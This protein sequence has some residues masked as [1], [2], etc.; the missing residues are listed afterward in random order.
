MENPSTTDIIIRDATEED[1]PFMNRVYNYNV[2]NSVGLFF[3]SPVTDEYR[4]RWFRT[5]KGKSIAGE[6]YPCLIGLRKGADGQE[7]KFGYVCYIPWMEGEEFQRV[8]EISLYIAQEHTGLGLGVELL[9]A[10]LA[11][12]STRQL[13]GIVARI[14]TE[15]ISSIKFFSKRGFVYSGQLNNVGYKFGRWLDV[16][17]YTLYLPGAPDSMN[18]K[19]EHESGFVSS[20]VGT[21]LI[22]DTQSSIA[23]VSHHGTPTITCRDVSSS[24]LPIGV[25]PAPLG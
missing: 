21:D 16:A 18:V 10:I 20:K 24:D 8:A 11:H 5:L 13:R 2:L 6:P 17:T 25:S 4:L 14:T 23:W 22:D 3:T 9:T 1:L 12:Q 7:T 19:V 15:N